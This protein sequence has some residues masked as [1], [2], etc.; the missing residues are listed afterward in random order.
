MAANGIHVVSTKVGDRHVL[1]ALEAEGLTLGGEQ[2][3][4]I[5]FR[6]VATTG[7]GLLTGLR[8]LDIVRRSG[9]TL[10]ELATSAMTRLP[11]VLRNVR[12]S[13]R[14]GLGD[15]AP[16]WAEVAAVEAALGE[17]GRVLLRPSGTEPVVRVMVE[18]TTEAD[19]EAAVERLCVAVTSALGRPA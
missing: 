8:L 6:D 1:E 9:R 19:A 12:V 15:A 14:D 3:G 11:Q 13:D 2:S 17:R 4:H 18:A 7:D 10:S 5:I 16:V